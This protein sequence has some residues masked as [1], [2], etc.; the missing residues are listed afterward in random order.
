MIAG[1]A[2]GFGTLIVAIGFVVLAVTLAIARL[3]GRFER[4]V[5]KALLG[6]VF[7]SRHPAP[8][9]WRAMLR[10][11]GTWLIVVYLLVR[12]PLG[13]AGFI[14]AALMLSAIPAMAAPLVYLLFPLAI[15]SEEAILISL[16]GCVFYL[17]A[18]HLVNA[19]AGISRRLAVAL[20]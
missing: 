18:A 17:L 15:H 3:F 2:V 5:S 20:L 11:R 7:E 1:L 16:F 4:E 6:A 8:P 14:A 19:I 13:I 12:F 10:D 9:G